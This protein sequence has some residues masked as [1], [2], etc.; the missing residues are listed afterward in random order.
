MKKIMSSVFKNESSKPK[1]EG[2]RSFFNGKNER[3][4]VTDSQV[5]QHEKKTDKKIE[6]ISIVIN[7]QR[8]GLSTF[9][10]QKIEDENQK[11]N[12]RK[13]KEVLSKIHPL[14]VEAITSHHHQGNNGKAVNRK[15]T[16]A[17]FTTELHGQDKKL[18]KE[19]NEVEKDQ[20]YFY[21]HYCYPKKSCSLQE[22]PQIKPHPLN[23]LQ[24]RILDRLDQTFPQGKLCFLEE[25][26]RAN[27]KSVTGSKSNPTTSNTKQDVQK[28]NKF[29]S[30]FAKAPKQMSSLGVEQQV[31]EN[32][33]ILPKST[34]FRS[35]NPW[36]LHPMKRPHH[37]HPS[38]M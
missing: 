10:R 4:P 29:N 18:A 20:S 15:R 28:E 9:Q 3:N 31:H 1:E 7:S 25:D 37:L 38:G 6:Q 19:S 11:M 24:T 30:S 5:V 12:S 21:S 34:S 26:G 27:E 32:L 33:P 36:N 23:L 13:D 17:N 22:E 2:S 35:T 14:S 16:S 8:N